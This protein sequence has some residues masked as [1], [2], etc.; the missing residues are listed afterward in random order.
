MANT[1]GAFGLMPLG[2]ILS[3]N[4]YG[5][6]AGATAIYLG[7]P[8]KRET[9][10]TATGL[11]TV[12]IATAAA[13][14]GSVIAIFDST[15]LPVS[16]YPG[17]STSGYTCIVADDP[18]QEFIVRED[19]DSADVAQANLGLNANLVAGT[20]NST[21]GRSGWQLDSDSVNTTATLMVNIMRLYQIPGNTM[22][23]D[24]AVYVVKAN[25]HQ[26]A[27]GTGTAGV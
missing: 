2:K 15:G 4:Q 7:D 26:R 14:T 16:R 1:I 10:G 17:D 12:T 3:K 25:N 9:T 24:N 23:E 18:N 20:G 5:I 8:V 22:G 6:V 11:A 27:A 13:F 21:T 19:S